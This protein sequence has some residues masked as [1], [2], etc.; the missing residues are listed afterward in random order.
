MEEEGNVGV[1][2]EGKGKVGVKEEGKVKNSIDTDAKPCTENQRKK[3]RLSKLKKRK[4]K[5]ELFSC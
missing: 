3:G 2:E 5:K 4:R 1:E